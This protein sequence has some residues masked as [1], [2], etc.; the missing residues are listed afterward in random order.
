M[1]Q[2][3]ALA[4]LLTISLACAPAFSAP[5]QK[6]RPAK[7]KSS[8]SSLLKRITDYINSEPVQKARVSAAVAAVRGGIPTD[9]GENLDERLLDRAGELRARLLAAPA[10]AHEHALRSI[11]RALAVSQM[12]QSTELTPKPAVAQEISSSLKDVSKSFADSLRA[13]LAGPAEALNDKA[14]VA[15]GWAKHVRDLTPSLSGDAP[16][17][18]DLMAPEETARLDETLKSLQA[19]WSR[20]ALPPSEEA[21]AHFLAADASSYITGQVWGVNGGLDM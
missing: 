10:Q 6:P 21:E 12:V 11:Y 5:V 16:A 17:A 13:L 9:Q 3:T 4:A 2:R 1:N 19:A 15:A 18:G 7:P 14:L 8:L 20:K